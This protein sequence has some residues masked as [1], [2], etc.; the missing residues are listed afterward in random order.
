MAG[1]ENRRV[2]RAQNLETVQ[3]AINPVETPPQRRGVQVAAA[4]YRRQTWIRARPA[5]KYVADFVGVYP[6]TRLFA[7]LHEKTAA[8]HIIVGQRQ[9]TTAAVGGAAALGHVHQRFPKQFLVHC[10]QHFSPGAP[11]V[12]R[13]GEIGRASVRARVRQYGETSGGAVPLKKKKRN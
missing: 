2:E 4:Q 13:Q 12:K 10:D 11:T 7:P 9:A 8:R 1:G 6:T 5:G 3:H